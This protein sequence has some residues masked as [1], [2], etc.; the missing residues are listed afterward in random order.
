M[1]NRTEQ[2]VV[3]ATT[4]AASYTKRAERRVVR[5][6]RLYEGRVVEVTIIYQPAIQSAPSG[7]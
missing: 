5:D 2:R 7:A 3:E 6:G 4:I 1:V